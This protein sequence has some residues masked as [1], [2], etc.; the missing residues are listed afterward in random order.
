MTRVTPGL[1]LICSVTYLLRAIPAVPEDL[2]PF[3]GRRFPSYRVRLGLDARSCYSAGCIFHASHDLSSRIRDPRS[4]RDKV[5]QRPAP[6][7]LGWNG[8]TSSDL[9]SGDL[10]SVVHG[11]L[12]Y[13]SVN[14]KHLASCTP[15]ISLLPLLDFL[16]STSFL[17][18][19][20][21]RSREQHHHQ[22]YAVS[23]RMGFPPDPSL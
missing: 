5:C 8:P 20:E 23:W 3:R 21:G 9:L 4:F 17:L 22:G 18:F 7:G 15:D 13:V 2:F 11:D 12:V 6:G 19:S 10:V 16:A 1:D 14:N